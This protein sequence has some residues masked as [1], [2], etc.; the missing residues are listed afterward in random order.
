MI[1]LSFEYLWFS[2]TLY[3]SF[4]ALTGKT[5]GDSIYADVGSSAK[6]DRVC[7][8]LYV[9]TMKKNSALDLLHVRYE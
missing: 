8:S 9:N 6:L 7:C 5:H 2:S 3:I 4:Y 1:L